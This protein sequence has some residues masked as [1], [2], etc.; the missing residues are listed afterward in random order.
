V[1]AFLKQ[2]NITSEF[3][4]TQR[5]ILIASEFDSQTLS[6]SA[7]LIRNN[8]DISCYELRP[9]KTSN[10]HFFEFERVLPGEKEEDYFV[11]IEATFSESSLEEHSKNRHKRKSLPRMPMLF[12]WGILKAGDVVQIKNYPDSEAKVID[13][14]TVQFKNGKLTFNQWGQTV[15]GWSSICIYEWAV[16]S[17]GTK[18]LHQLRLERLQEIEKASARQKEA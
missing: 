8:V 13:T 4:K 6:S 3:N 7:W 9:L 2:H 15:T 5:I 18:T 16:L 1:N 14:K 10:Q 12:E 17:S 11:G